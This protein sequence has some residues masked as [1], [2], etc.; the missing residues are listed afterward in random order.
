MI[1]EYEPLTVPA[2]QPGPPRRAESYDFPHDALF[3]TE[4]LRDYFAA[5]GASGSS[6]PGAR[7]ASGHRPR[8]QNAI[9]PVPRPTA[10]ELGARG[11]PAA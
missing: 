8:F 5:H 6:P 10:A 4:I 11:T 3:S 7:R 9:T 1:Q 2:G